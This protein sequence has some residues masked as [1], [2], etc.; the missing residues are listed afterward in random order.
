MAALRRRRIMHAKR[1]TSGARK[2]MWWLLLDCGHDKYVT[3]RRGA[4]ALCS[5]CMPLTQEKAK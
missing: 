5:K 3:V 2:G 4:H 1:A